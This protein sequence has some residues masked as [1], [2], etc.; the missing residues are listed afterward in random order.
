M[1][2]VAYRKQWNVAAPTPPVLVQVVA[3][4]D[5]AKLL[6]AV[7]TLPADMLEL[8]DFAAPH[9]LAGVALQAGKLELHQAF[10]EGIPDGFAPFA[11]EGPLVR[12][13]CE[14]AEGMGV[15]IPLLGDCLSER[16]RTEDLPMVIPAMTH[17]L[18]AFST[19]NSHLRTS[20]FDATAAARAVL[21][22][23][24]LAAQERLAKALIDE[25]DMLSRIV[26]PNA[27]GD[28]MQLSE[29]LSRF[30][31]ALVKRLQ[32]LG[33]KTTAERLR[34]GCRHV[35]L[36]LRFGIWL[37]QEVGGI[38]V[39]YLTLAS[40][41]WTCRVK[42]TWSRQRAKP[43][44]LARAVITDVLDFC[45]GNYETKKLE[46]GSLELSLAES[47]GRVLVPSIPEGT[48]KALLNKG[49]STL[50]SDVGLDLLEWQIT[51]A[52]QQY[53]DEVSPY[54]R[55]VVKGGWSALAN[56][57]LGLTH[58]DGPQ[59]VRSAVFA[60]G[61]LLFDSRGYRGNLVAFREPGLEAPGRRATITMTLGDMML[62]DFFLTLRERLNSN[63]LTAREAAKLVPILGRT[64]L[65]GRR[66]EHVAQRRMAWRFNIAFKE[67]EKEL[68]RD[69]FVRISDEDWVRFADESGAPTSP[70]F[71]RGVQDA[72]EHGDAKSPPL[73]ARVNGE[74]DGFTLH[75]SR[76]DALDFVRTG[77]EITLEMQRQARR[78]NKQRKV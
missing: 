56:E 42:D 33:D 18:L 34:D 37:P 31:F 15:A 1:S 50:T 40:S 63:S 27:L 23:E 54:N 13:I 69:G 35:P 22:N 49:I 59:E 25:L 45:S 30:D 9:K 11:G 4:V 47:R 72:W 10:G 6:A 24:P 39:A 5:G 41:L 44:A 14:T 26:R 70:V 2:A 71:I 68:A 53:L 32:A 65:Y 19:A 76:Q 78:K 29:G 51:T 16:L 8:L 62:P 48:M 55:I 46:D 28:A 20:C 21:S 74:R 17:P 52:H 61:N 7:E 67:K 73:L 38:P 60:Q 36:E 66:N 58:K 12:T 75:P 64:P 77:G 43:P 57:H 3:P